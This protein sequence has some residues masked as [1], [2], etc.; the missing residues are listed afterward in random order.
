MGERKKSTTKA[1]HVPRTYDTYYYAPVCVVYR[2]LIT[3]R[4]KIPKMRRPRGMETINKT[5]INVYRTIRTLF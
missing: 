1:R 5:L 4:K 2:A 3:E